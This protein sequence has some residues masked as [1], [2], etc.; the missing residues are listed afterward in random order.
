MA[1]V[2]LHDH[3]E[4]L[5]Q[6]QIRRLEEEGRE[7]LCFAVVFAHQVYYLSE[8][9]EIVLLALLA[10]A[11]DSGRL[12][13]SAAVTED[14]PALR[15]EVLNMPAS[16]AA[17]A[18]FAERK[19]LPW[20]DLHAPLHLAPVHIPKPW[21][22]EIW[23]TG[24]EVRGQSAVIAQELT[25]P[26]PWILSL[27]P[28]ALAGGHERELIL[29]K[30][31]D[32]LPD[33]VYGDLYFEMHEQKQEVYIVTCI[34]PQAYPA[35]QGAIR[36]GF[37]AAVRAGYPSDETF[38]QA[39][40]RAVTD[41]REIRARIDALFDEK[42]S[43]LNIG[44]S[45]P[46]PATRLKLWH[47]AL[48]AALIQEEREKRLRMDEFTALRP[49][50]LGDVVRVPCYVPHALQHGV[51]TVE[52][53][54]PVYERKILSFAQKVLT[55]SEWDTEQ[56][57]KDISVASPIV[58]PMDILY[59]QAGILLERIARFADFEVCRLTLD[60]HQTWTFKTHDCYAILL[61]ISGNL[62][63]GDDAR[64]RRII[65]GSLEHKAFLLPASTRGYQL[66]SGADSAVLLLATPVENPIV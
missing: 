10:L 20:L 15:Q 17:F 21:G 11:Q 4:S 14:I 19:Q 50:Q 45:E 12:R 65:D 25:T 49:L 35:G 62:V 57:L 29:L 5:I 52:F 36:L 26:L 7:S 3:P 32:P 30:I 2:Y 28:A 54:T 44:L 56:A 37:S 60:A 66:E 48:P 38:K 58:Q 55:Q 6:Q 43:A 61:L 23:Y 41:Y 13:I 9:E 47:Q 22:Q 24:I 27:M 39:Y 18:A 1:A 64:D 31:L 42:R 59:Q 8:P 53:Q 16:P 51:R 40:L 46:L 34:D 33:E 63:I